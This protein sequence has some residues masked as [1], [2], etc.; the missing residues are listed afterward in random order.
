MHSTHR[1]STLW[2]TRAAQTA[3]GRVGGKLPAYRRLSPPSTAPMTIYYCF[4]SYLCVHERKIVS[5]AIAVS[6]ITTVDR[7]LWKEHNASVLMPMPGCL[8]RRR[9]AGHVVHL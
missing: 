7:G 9:L 2:R 6:H 1:P 3:S 5:T 8:A 4:S